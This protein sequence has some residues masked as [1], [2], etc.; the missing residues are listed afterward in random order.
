MPII[1]HNKMD[2]MAIRA[3]VIKMFGGMSRDSFPEIACQPSERYPINPMPSINP[4]NPHVNNKSSAPLHP[5][6]LCFLL[7]ILF[8]VSA[9][10][11]FLESGVVI[12]QHI[13]IMDDEWRVRT[14]NFVPIL[15]SEQISLYIWHW[16]LQ[17]RFKTCLPT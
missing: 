4:R 15:K 11:E 5:S 7:G 2:I 10:K 16:K 17:Y 12:I 8:C 9:L 1:P 3:P 14:F 13:D 6:P